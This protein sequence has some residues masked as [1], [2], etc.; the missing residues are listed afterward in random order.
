MKDT[1]ITITHL[2][3]HLMSSFLRPGRRVLLRKDRDNP[4]DDEA[5]RV[6]SENGNALGYVA[7]CTDTVAR[8]TFSSG[9]LYDRF[10]EE[11]E[12]EISFLRDDFAI[13]KILL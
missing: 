6:Y 2:N 1:Y 9:R 3:E 10:E 8:G 7:N 12:G 4:Y 5:I 13:A 11:A